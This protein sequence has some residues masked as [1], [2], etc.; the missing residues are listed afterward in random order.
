MDA[1]KQFTTKEVVITP[2]DTNKHVKFIGTAVSKSG[3]D[4]YYGQKQ[5]AGSL[6]AISVKRAGGFGGIE[7]RSSFYQQFYKQDQGYYNSNNQPII[8][9]N[10]VGFTQKSAQNIYTVYNSIKHLYYSN[11]LSRSMGDYA[12]TESLFIGSDSTGNVKRGVVIPTFTGSF[13]P[14]MSTRYENYLM[15]TITPT[16]S[17]IEQNPSG[18]MGN[19]GEFITSYPTSLNPNLPVKTYELAVF[20][21]PKKLYGEY[22]MPG[23]FK[24][25]ITTSY[26]GSNANTGGASTQL[27]H[28]EFLTEIFDDGEGN[29]FTNISGSFLSPEATATQIGTGSCEKLWCGNMFYQHGIGVVMDKNINAYV[30]ANMAGTRSVVFSVGL[31]PHFFQSTTTNDDMYPGTSPSFPDEDYPKDFLPDSSIEFSSSLRLYEHQYKCV[32]RDN[33]FNYSLNK[34][35]L[36]GSAGVNNNVYFDFATSSYFAPYITTVGLY[37]KNKELMAVGKLAVPTKMPNNS[38]LTIMVNLTM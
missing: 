12:V 25:I 27:G 17:F 16:R 13:S 3:I 30:R 22:I 21:I 18:T 37:N 23:S 26:S 31:A 6:E 19:W 7:N 33:E 24:Y 32:V 28:Y 38:D 9:S 14:A 4:Y 34:S 10:K 2:Y 1:Y 35:L 15:N 11:F 36:T 5:T 8:A 29:L 20:S